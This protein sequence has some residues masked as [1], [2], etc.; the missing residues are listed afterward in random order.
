MRWNLWKL[1]YGFWV[2]TALNS[3]LLLPTTSNQIRTIYNIIAAKYT[4]WMDESAVFPDVRPEH[5]CVGPDLCVSDLRLER[6]TSEELTLSH[7]RR[8]ATWSP[9]NS[10]RNPCQNET[11]LNTRE[12]GG[13]KIGFASFM[14]EL[15]Y[16]EIKAYIIDMIL[17]QT[18]G[19][20]HIAAGCMQQHSH[21]ERQ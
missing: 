21:V 14:H 16:F 17:H 1:P 12:A 18:N 5:W 6:Q 20:G 15:N 4:F 11:A 13:S 10:R 3:H 8:N 7:T 2:G 19:C 9:L